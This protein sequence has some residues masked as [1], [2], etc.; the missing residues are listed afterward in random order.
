MER[1]EKINEGVGIIIVEKIGIKGPIEC[2]ITVI[3]VALAVAMI[4]VCA[5]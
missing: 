4:L 5:R 3:V 1:V 2:W